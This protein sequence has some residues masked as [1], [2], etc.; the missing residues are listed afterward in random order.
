[1]NHQIASLASGVYVYNQ[2]A[3]QEVVV[4]TSGVGADRDT[5]GMQL[6][7]VPRDGGNVFSGIATFAYVGASFEM[8]NVNDELLARNLDPN[9]IGSL[10]KFRDSA[11]A[12]GGPMRANRLWFF[13]A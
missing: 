7:M 10:K 12:L 6:N 8:S 3:S 13:A 4:E 11:A 9:R 5:G 1:M 2:I